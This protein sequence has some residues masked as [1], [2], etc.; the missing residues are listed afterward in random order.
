MSEWPRATFIDED[1][2]EYYWNFWI[3]K[4]RDRFCLLYTSPSQRDS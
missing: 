1:G 4:D 3:K 2:D